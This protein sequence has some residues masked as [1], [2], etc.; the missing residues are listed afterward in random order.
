MRGLLSG[1]FFAT[2]A[3]I[4]LALTSVHGFTPTQAGLALT[5]G[6]LGWSAA[7]WFQGRMDRPRPA[8]LVLGAVLITAG[9]AGIAVGTPFWAWSAIPAWIV[10]GA[11]MGLAY[12]TI[13][14]LVLNLSA[15]ADQGTNSAALQISDTLGGAL[16]IGVA[17]ALV[18]GF[19]AD[20]LGPGLAAAGVLTVVIALV[21]VVAAIRVTGDEETRHA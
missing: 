21:A 19:G 15:P 2:E 10:A 14:V 12:G 13:S 3:F 5:L 4:P 8:L 1:A 9:V 6:A 17:G 11:G 16:G 7:S 18:T 20:R